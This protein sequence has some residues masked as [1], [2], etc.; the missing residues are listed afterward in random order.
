MVMLELK[1]PWRYLDF[2]NLA[3]FS[4]GVKCVFG[5]TEKCFCV[6]RN[7]LNQIQMEGLVSEPLRIHL[8]YAKDI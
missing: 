2:L 1:I 6:S 8:E 7:D 5:F 4:E 3:T